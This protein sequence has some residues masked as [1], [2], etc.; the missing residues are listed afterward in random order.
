MKLLGGA[1]HQRGMAPRHS[2]ERLTS[3]V[4]LGH[5][6]L[7]VVSVPDCLGEQPGAVER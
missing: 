6:E 3:N 2:D 5:Q 7:G 4:E 1:P